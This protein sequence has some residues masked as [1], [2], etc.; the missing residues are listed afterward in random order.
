MSWELWALLGLVIGVLLGWYLLF[1]A[2]RL[3]RLHRR[4]EGA[5]AALDNQLLRRATAATE[6]AG[7]G[8]LDPASSLL[9]ASAAVEAIEAGE[10]RAA[11]VALDPFSGSRMAEHDADREA[12][13]SDLSRALRA[14]L[15]E[16]PEDHPA[17]AGDH[18]EAL[19]AVCHRVCL[20]RRFHNDAV[21]QAQAVRRKRVVRMAR[22]QGRAPV[23]QT[24]EMDDEP[25]RILVGHGV[26]S[27]R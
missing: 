11:Q 17:V 18:L 16:L 9:V 27:A 4:V 24:V 10:G 23:P 5:Q 7:S 1:I 15:D 12:A 13:E 22:L 3:D 14:T 2:R 25:P 26:P 8:V 20:A 21:L 19:A 6:L